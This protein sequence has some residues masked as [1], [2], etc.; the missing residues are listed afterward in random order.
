M[1]AMFPK[2]G[3][4]IRSDQGGM[5]IYLPKPDAASL[6]QAL[7][8]L[9]PVYD[10]VFDGPPLR[11]IHK[12]HQGRHVFYFANLG[13]TALSTKIPLRGHLTPQ[14]WNPHNGTISSPIFTTQSTDR[15]DSTIVEI[16]LPPTSSMFVVSRLETR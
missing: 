15:Q 10:L 5:A 12:I 9:R 2:A 13:L 1:A 16:A 8:A 14:R 4:M 7:D 3:E 6:R 11:Y